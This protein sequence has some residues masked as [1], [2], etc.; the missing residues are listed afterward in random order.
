[1]G[2]LYTGYGDSG[3]T[4]CAMSKAK[5]PKDH[6][7]IEIMGTLDE[8]SSTIGLARSLLPKEAV[9]VDEV[10][11]EMQR[12]LY[13]VASHISGFGEVGE[14]DITFLEKVADRYYGEPL[15]EFVL[16][17]HPPSAAALHVARTVVRRLERRYIS[18][19]RKGYIPRDQILMK[20]INRMSDAL[21]A[22]AIYL[23]RRYGGGPEKAKASD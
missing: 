5:V 4:Y 21:F 14:N 19:V 12:L 18:A 6:P 10:L 9:G 11:R 20:L 13:R 15:K 1:L 16:P 23:Q 17:G 8:A 22:V 2:S 3:Y 7:V